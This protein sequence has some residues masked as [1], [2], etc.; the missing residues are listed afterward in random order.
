VSAPLSGLLC[1][2]RDSSHVGADASSL[3]PYYFHRA[4]I[5]LG[6]QNGNFSPPCSL[7]TFPGPTLLPAGRPQQQIVLMYSY[8]LLSNHYSYHTRYAHMRRRRSDNSPAA[9]LTRLSLSIIETFHELVTAL[10]YSY[11]RR[12]SQNLVLMAGYVSKR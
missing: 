6:S 3:W 8:S 1:D 5:L 7:P 4:T 2:S 12:R 10:E 9:P 11:R